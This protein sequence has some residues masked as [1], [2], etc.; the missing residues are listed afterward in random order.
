MANDK[1][2]QWGS[3]RENYTRFINNEVHINDGVMRSSAFPYHYKAITSDHSTFIMERAAELVCWSNGDVLNIGFGMGIIDT[4]ISNKPIK[5][6]TIIEAH[7]DIYQHAINLGFDKRAK[8]HL[9]DWRDVIKEFIEKGIKFDGIYFHTV[10]FDHVHFNEYT[11]FAKQFD[12][13]MRVGG[14]FAY[15]N[16]YD[17]YRDPHLPKVIVD[18]GYEMVVERIPSEKIYSVIDR[19]PDEKLLNKQFYNSVWYIKQ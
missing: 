15:Y 18:Q 14:L 17:S 6:H 13:I 11:E 16:D 8:L 2:I 4:Y 3:D 1:G 10:D 7:P 5:S 9:G 12:K 19:T